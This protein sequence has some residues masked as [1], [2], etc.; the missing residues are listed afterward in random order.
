MKEQIT[1]S[2]IQASKPIQFTSKRET[3][4]SQRGSEQRECRHL[5]SQSANR[6]QQ[7]QIQFPSS[8]PTKK[9]PRRS[10]SG[11]T[12]STTSKSIGTVAS[13][14]TVTEMLIP[15]T[16]VPSPTL[17]ARNWMMPDSGTIDKNVVCDTPV[18]MRMPLL[19]WIKQLLMTKEVEM[20]LH[21]P[22]GISCGLMDKIIRTRNSSPAVPIIM[23][24]G[25]RFYLL[26]RRESRS[27]PL[28]SA[29]TT[30]C[31]DVDCKCFTE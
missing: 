21:L 7:P 17:V 15:Q 11:S 13:Y 1:S 26:L 29:D 8:C 25:S 24:P 28:R 23:S 16:L 18:R 19:L 12:I 3:S 14:I 2:S 27:T 5:I 9:E 4:Q 30:I 22:F 10:R 6:R 31:G 20:C